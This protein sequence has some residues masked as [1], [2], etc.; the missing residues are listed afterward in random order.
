MWKR[1][2][3]FFCLIAL[4]LAAPLPDTSLYQLPSR[5]SDQEGRSITLPDL[6]GKVQVLAMIYTHCQSVCP[7]ILE[8]MKATEGQLTA[9][10]RRRVGF[11][12]VSID[13]RVDTSAQL[14]A[15]ADEKKLGPAWRLLRGSP[16]DVREL[17]ATLDFKYRKTSSKD[18]AHSAMITVLDPQGEVLHQQVGLSGGEAERLKAIQQCLQGR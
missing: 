7:A 2:L 11:V 15:Y 1:C 10:E 12:L 5:W 16:E 18:Y 8:G 14:K 9:S 6:Q 17:A 3:W 4:A 13:P